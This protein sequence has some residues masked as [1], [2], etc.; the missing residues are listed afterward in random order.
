MWYHRA[1][2]DITYKSRILSDYMSVTSIGSKNSLNAKSSDVQS[3]SINQTQNSENLSNMDLNANLN[4]S[5]LNALS[6]LNQKTHKV[7]SIGLVAS[8]N[9]VCFVKIVIIN[10]IF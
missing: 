1:D 5:S 9:Q 7:R 4:S 8:A 3:Q 2:F 10:L 6:Y